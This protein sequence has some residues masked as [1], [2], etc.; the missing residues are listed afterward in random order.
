M[1][2]VLKFILQVVY[3][4]LFMT[5]FFVTGPFFLWRLWRRGKILPQFGQRFGFY[6][7]DVRER[8]GPGCDL[9]IHAVS[10][11]EVKLARVLV[12]C[13]R[14]QRPELRIVLSTTTGTGFSLAK[15]LLEDERTFIIYNP[16]DFLWSVVSAFNAVKPKRLILIE[17]E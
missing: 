17:S 2:A 6:S 1:R 15:E 4:V 8:L 5:F 10:V 16:I 3:N 9:W 7:K 12:R 13:L 14:D 11:G